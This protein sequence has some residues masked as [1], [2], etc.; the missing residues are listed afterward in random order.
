MTFFGTLLFAGGHKSLYLDLLRGLKARSSAEE[1][2][3]VS[4]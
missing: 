3:A 1:K 2:I 4:V